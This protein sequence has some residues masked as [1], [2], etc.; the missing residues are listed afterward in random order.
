MSDSTAYE[1]ALADYFA[2]NATDGPYNA[3]TDRPAMLALAGDV[4]GLR[5]LDVGC[6]AGHYIAELRARGA[7]EVVGVEGSAT[8]LDHARDRTGADPAVT[9]HRHDL[10]EPLAFL[11]DD[12]FDLCVVALVHHHLD[13]RRE[14]L[15]ELHRVLRPGGTL[16]LSTVHPTADWVWHG[17]SYFDED[18]VVTRFGDSGATN[19]YRRMTM[20]TFLNELLDTGLV[21]ERLV[22]PRATEAA[23]QV[24]EARYRKTHQTPFFVAVR[25]RKVQEKP[26]VE[27]GRA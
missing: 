19:S 27:E 3:H 11:P 2:G 13:A 12:S 20:Q 25:M 10:E 1:G 6:G 26:W 24:D 21:L 17:G 22:E 7:A 15:A 8:L 23:R 4:R 18:R 9:L 5:V 16:L 14:L